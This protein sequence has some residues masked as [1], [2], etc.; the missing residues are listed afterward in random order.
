M[1]RAVESS[2]CVTDTFNV[3]RQEPEIFIGDLAKI[4][5]DVVGKNITIVAQPDTLGSPERRCPDISRVFSKIDY[6]PL[7]GLEEGIR[8]MFEWYRTNVFSEKERSAI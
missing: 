1:V 7:V 8:K 2:A 4:V 3:G 5:V 6:A